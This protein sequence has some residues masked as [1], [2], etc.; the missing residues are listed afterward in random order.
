M[1]LFVGVSKKK[2]PHHKYVAAIKSSLRGERTSF[3][4]TQCEDDRRYKMQMIDFEAKYLN[5]IFF[6]SFL[7]GIV[8]AT[9][10]LSKS[11]IV[12]LD[13]NKIRED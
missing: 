11:Y 6:T 8:T 9:K 2:I 10:Y 13:I 12:I 4:G 1:M 5:Y 3:N 7:R